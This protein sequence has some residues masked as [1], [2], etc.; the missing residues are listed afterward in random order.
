MFY[1]DIKLIH[2]KFYRCFDRLSGS[3]MIN[4]FL[5]VKANYDGSNPNSTTTEFSNCFKY[6]SL[7]QIELISMFIKVNGI[8][9]RHKIVRNGDWDLLWS[10]VS[11]P[12]IC[13]RVL[14]QKDIGCTLS[15]VSFE[16]SNIRRL[17][18]IITS[19]HWTITITI[20]SKFLAQDNDFP[21]FWLVP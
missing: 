16:R 9:V 3:L 13:G 18:G 7:L 14:I 1:Q 20:I 19:L 21:A 12:T 11:L 4:E 2:V 17:D 15:I 10:T 6:L 5:N 8:C